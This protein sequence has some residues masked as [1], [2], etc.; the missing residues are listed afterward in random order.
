MQMDANLKTGI[1]RQFGAVIDYP[2]AQ[3]SAPARTTFGCR[4]CGGTP[5]EQPASR[6]SGTPAYH[7]LFWLDLY[8]WRGG[9]VR[10]PGSLRPGCRWLV[11]AAGP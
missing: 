4:R 8:V 5:N 10:P 11:A 9:R 7:T 1:W 3:P 6:S 2:A